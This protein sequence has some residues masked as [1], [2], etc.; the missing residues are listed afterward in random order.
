MVESHLED[1]HPQHCYTDAHIKSVESCV[2]LGKYPPNYSEFTLGLGRTSS[3]LYSVWQ[4]V[5]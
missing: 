5:T 3:S 1:S 4:S 2:S